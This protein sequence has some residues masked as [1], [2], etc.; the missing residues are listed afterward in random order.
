MADI[1][2]I[3]AGA[4][5]G[6]THKLTQIL[7][8]EIGSGRV[9]AHAVLATTF[10]RKAAAE[11]RERVRS[12]LLRDGMT[13]EAN[14][15]QAAFIGMV[16][17]V[18]GELVSI[19]AFLLG[20]SPGLRVL[21]EV[22]AELLLGEALG[23][24][25]DGDDGEAL[26]ALQERMPRFT[27]RKI[28]KSVID[29]ARAN[30]IAA[31]GL[32]QSM[33]R[34]E[35]ELDELL[36]PPCP[37][38]LDARLL[39]ALD[40]ALEALAAHPDAGRQTNRDAR[41]VLLGHRERLARGAALPWSTW[42][43]LPKTKVT[44]PVT[45]AGL[46]APL[47]SVTAEV[48]RHSG[49]H[50]DLRNAVRLVFGL[51]ADVLRAYEEKKRG[52]GVID[53]T[54]QETYFLEL[55][56]HEEARE[57][58]RE[59]I[60][61]VLVDEFQ[62]TSPL[63]LELFRRLADVVSRSYWVGDP[64]QAIYGF[65][66][67]DSALMDAAVKA[68]KPSDFLR[69]SYRS[70]P[71]LV[72]LTSEMFVPPFAQR[73][74][75]PELIRLEPKPGSSDDEALGPFAEVW[76]LHG[77]G[78][79]AL[80]A[81]TGEFLAD[82]SVRVRDPVSDEVRRA[83]A[84]DVAI[85]CFTN[86]ECTR[87]ANALVARGIGV[88]LGR[89]GLLARPEVLLVHG[90]LRLW[91]DPH[92]GL[93]KAELARLV[94]YAEDGDGFLRAALGGAGAFDEHETVARVAA[95]RQA[96]PTAGLL[97]V[98]DRVVDAVEA[99]LRC[100]E[101]GDSE[102]RLA[103]L[104]VLRSHCAR[105]A[106]AAEA[107][108]RPVTVAGFL[109]ELERLSGAKKDR[110]AVLRSDAAAGA[111][112]VSTWHGAKGLEWPV[113]V[114]FEIERV[115][116][117]EVTAARIVSEGGFDFDAPLQ[118]RWIRLWIDPT[119][120]NQKNTELHARFDA[121]PAW[122][123][124]QRE[125]DNEMLR[126]LYVG[127]TRARDRVVLASGSALTDC[128]RL[129]ALSPLLVDAPEGAS[130][131]VPLVWAGVPLQVRVRDGEPQP[132]QPLSPRPG[133]GVMP[134]GPR[135]HPD[136]RVRPSSKLGRA[137]LGR[138]ERFGK[139]LQ[140][141]GDAEVMARLGDC[142]HAFLAADGPELDEAERIKTASV[143]ASRWRFGG[144]LGFRSLT[145]AGDGLRSW[146]DGRWPGATWRREWPVLVRLE[147]GQVLGGIC[148]LVLEIADG[149][150]LIDHKCV[151]GGEMH[152]L[153]RITEYG[154][155]LAAYAEALTAA[156]GRPVVETWLHLPLHGLAVPVTGVGPATPDATRDPDPDD[157]DW[158]DDDL[159]PDD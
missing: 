143:L 71:G 61:L 46:L 145:Q 77:N 132:S 98:F 95:S 157:G 63:Q 40:H 121:H 142:V 110:Q 81:A 87:V 158:F 102:Q 18:C 34:S 37:D 113:T 56:A 108:R 116:R 21:D 49:L 66:G 94:H 48:F 96:R 90:G 64:K 51:A 23:E 106:G 28:I 118:G 73:G 29:Q 82:A 43:S 151:S 17:A 135:A 85:L 67:T 12:Q 25:A 20:L 42:I 65:R 114:L 93:A 52:L 78:A 159:A 134:R 10:T 9:A 155:Q 3:S 58:L 84:G 70:R 104:D 30:R 125:S 62:D 53:F 89:T 111:V 75:Q 69:H 83:T 97:E 105:Y 144:T 146:V 129:A 138:P 74:L 15:L 103:N 45:R 123:D 6:K 141:P 156:T 54:D 154:G 36:G 39:A 4:G 130:G 101:W 79:E 139:P 38:D 153:E 19:H 107:N 109:D 1:R 122:R 24:V 68:L 35:A 133:A 88:V 99:R 126:L 147:G 140:H 41:Q 100:L 115:R 152:A 57:W 72:A 131:C 60:D 149:L 31:V 11:L 44:V 76:R 22:E 5:S 150:V 33:R 112:T 55:L 8:E 32:E 124:V 119:H 7:G 27:Y 26:A 50:D 127:W 91:V 117:P 47:Q 137:E 120:T 2:L 128:E 16:N 136:L 148:D 59:R 92:D 86:D 14:A 13:V 80:A